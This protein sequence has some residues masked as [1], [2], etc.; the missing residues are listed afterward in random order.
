MNR[1][2]NR[3]TMPTTFKGIV[4]ILPMSGRPVTLCNNTV[5]RI[6]ALPGGTP[7]VIV[8]LHG[9]DIVR[10]LPNGD[11]DVRHCGYPGVVTFDRLRRFLPAGFSA[12]YSKGDP[13]ITRNG[14]RW[15]DVCNGIWTR[16]PNY[17]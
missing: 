15:D 6:D 7:V 4:D 8:S 14:K 3:M 17:A 12:T 9:H 1:I 16:V 11:V 10:L 5:A 2:A 13:R